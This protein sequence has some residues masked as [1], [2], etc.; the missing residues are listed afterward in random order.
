M[1]G[2]NGTIFAYG[3]TGTGK[4]YSMVGDFHSQK[5]KGI[6]P[7]AFDYI[8]EHV[9]NDQEYQYNIYVSFI[10]IY[11]ESISDLLD[12]KNKD[13][14]IREMGEQNVYLEGVQWARI[15]STEECAKVFQFG[16]KNRVTESTKMNSHS[17]R[18]HAIFIVK[19]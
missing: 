18:S 16:E 15:T 14:R 10:Q 19:I 6:I 4:T 13:I 11:L 3:Q 1:Q 7:R 17:S 2:Y 8:F 12:P 5:N 9:Q